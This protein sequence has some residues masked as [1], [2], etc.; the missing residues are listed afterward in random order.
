MWFDGAASQFKG[1]T[2]FYFVARYARLTGTGM[3]LFFFG[4]GH[5][6][7]EHNGVGVV[8]KRTLTHEQLKFN[9]SILRCASDVVSYCQA[10]L[11]KGALASYP[12]KERE[13][14]CVFWD[15]KL[16]DVNSEIKWN[17]ATIKKSCSLHGHNL[18]D[19]TA[20]GKRPIDMLL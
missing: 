2:P 11:S 12:S 20:L 4:L 7:G 9:G 3:S 10:N 14:S 15:I 1:A 13:C 19:P 5:G 18:Q 8:A 6:K 17:C 16:G